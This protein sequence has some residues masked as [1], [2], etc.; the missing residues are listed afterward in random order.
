[1]DIVHHIDILEKLLNRGEQCIHILIRHTFHVFSNFLII[2]LLG[3]AYNTILL[4]E[5]IVSQ[6]KYIYL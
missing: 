1:M 2:E 5:N 6:T 4:V 3:F